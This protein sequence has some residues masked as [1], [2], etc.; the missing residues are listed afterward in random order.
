MKLK[1]QLRSMVVVATGVVLLPVAALFFVAGEVSELREDAEDARVELAAKLD[2]T[3][4]VETY[5]REQRDRSAGFGDKRGDEDEGVLRKAVLEAFAKAQSG[6]DE[7]EDE[8]AEAK[9]QVSLSAEFVALADDAQKLGRFDSARAEEF[10]AVYDQ[11]FER[12]FLP[13]LF[14]SARDEQT[15]LSEALV[16]LDRESRQAGWIGAFALLAGA[17]ALLF[18]ARG[19]GARAQYGLSELLRATGALAKGTLDA[20][21]PTLPTQEFDEIG[22]SFNQMAASLRDATESKVRVEKLAAVGQLAASVGHEIRNPL[23]AARNALA[24]LR[25]RQ[26]Q[27]PLASDKRFADFIELADRELGACNRI[28]Q[29]L[30]DYARERP[31]TM[32]ACPLHA[33]TEEVLEIVRVRDDVEVKNELGP[34]LPP[35]DAD[36]DQLRQLIVN[37]VQNGAEAVPN[38]RAGRVR[39]SASL[40]GNR[41]RLSVEDDGCGIPETDRQRIFEPLVTT[42]TKGTGLGLAITRSIIARHGWTLALDS[43]LGKGTTFHVDIPL[44]GKKAAA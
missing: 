38:D 32:T 24:Y 37:L 26:A 16:S 15:Q 36:R 1:H 31:L 7:E 4:R 25:K 20:R 34:E 19:V 33:L 12:G 40:D 10:E 13:K 35:V 44:Q 3:A 11:R 8:H 30:L 42:K 23:S 14:K 22:R 21:V 39:I 27:T 2:L 9:E 18:I 6:G 28:V 29:D 17:G 5:F 41:L 43:E